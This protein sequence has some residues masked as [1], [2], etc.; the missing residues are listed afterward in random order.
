MKF[1][2]VSAMNH[3]AKVDQ[4]LQVAAQRSDYIQGQAVSQFETEWSKFCNTRHCV[5][6]GS[7]TDALIL[8]L[9]AMGIGPGDDV[10]V[11]ANT[12]IATVLAIAANGARPVFVDIHPM[13][14]NITPTTVAG[15]LT[16]NTKAIVVV[17]LMGRPVHIGGIRAVLPSH[18][19]ILEDSAQAHGACQLAGVA[20][21]YSFYPSK[22]LGA[23]GDAGAVVTNDPVLANSVRALANY[24]S[25][26]PKHEYK[27]LG[28]NSRMDTLQASVLLAKLPLLKEWNERRAR[29]AHWY[30]K[31][32]PPHVKIQTPHKDHV[33]HLFVI[34]TEQR[35]E[36]QQYLGER[37]IPT[38]THYPTPC[39]RQPLPF[40]EPEGTCLAAE[41]VAKKLLSLPMCPS[42]TYEDVMLVSSAINDFCR[43]A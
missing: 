18:V 15:A 32:L 16:P 19:Q 38:G 36:L 22:N 10:L 12:F 4:A 17:H 8:A 39:H 21:C 1:V 34:Q 3:E 11:P 28:R 26:G 9:A 14:L 13:E 37:G 35:D 27:A 30:R 40:E 6:V 24:G 25:F 41:S 31:A 42:T 7:G 2:D 20:A 23:L 29:V 5:A 33:Y 43:N